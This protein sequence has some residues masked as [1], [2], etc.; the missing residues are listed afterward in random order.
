MFPSDG[1]VP[2][3][4]RSRDA[5]LERLFLNHVARSAVSPS[6]RF[7]NG[8]GV[9]YGDSVMAISR[10]PRVSGLNA[11]DAALCYVATHRETGARYVGRTRRTLAERKKQ[12]ERDAAASRTNGPFPEALRRCGREAFTWRAV[13][14]GEEEAIKFLEAGLIDAWGT[15]RVGGLNAVGG[16][17]VPPVRDLRY[18]R[19]AEEMDRDVCLL[20]MFNDLEEV[21]RYVEK[22]GVTLR[23]DSLDALRDLATRLLTAVSC[24]ES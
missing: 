3:K 24:A 17:P 6:V 19:F 9:A 7:L 20:H 4:G 22:H 10:A 13:A 1:L 12:H 11:T 15:A 14:E 18:D 2:W 5:S 16:L 8:R 21:V 23:G